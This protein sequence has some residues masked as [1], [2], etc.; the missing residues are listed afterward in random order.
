[1]PHKETIRQLNA[2]LVRV[3]LHESRVM[4]KRELAERIGLPLSD[5]SRVVDDL[6]AA[7]E[8]TEHHSLPPGEDPQPILAFSLNRRA[9][10]TLH[11]RLEEDTLFWAVHEITG[12]K[13]D[14]GYESTTPA[15]I[16]KT[17]GA[18]VAR[19]RQNAPTLRYAILGLPC[20][21][22]EGKISAET[23][24]VEIR[25]LDIA[26]YFNETLQLQAVIQSN[27][28]LAA[29]GHLYQLP[30][31]PPETIIFL[32]RR[33]GGGLNI[34]R[35]KA[36]DFKCGPTGLTLIEQIP[37]LTETI[38]ICPD[39]AKA[40]GSI[41]D[42]ITVRY[43]PDCIIFYTDSRLIGMER[44]IRT[45]CESHLPFEARLEL[46]FSPTFED[47]HFCGQRIHARTLN[48]APPMIPLPIQS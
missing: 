45:F 23:C 10:L 47:D 35:A 34:C 9:R 37:P 33:A 17:L 8:L 7:N 5:I 39:T 48:P 13:L 20:P 14:Y 15:G 41:I 44:D 6:L 2:D 40:Y 30:A 3:A 38:A 32:Q 29:Q 4:S 21:V 24:P 46:T 27:I 36:D 25:S 16:L 18:L 12:G 43:K 11:L 26:S 28:R 42:E 22:A 19:L 31:I 1:M